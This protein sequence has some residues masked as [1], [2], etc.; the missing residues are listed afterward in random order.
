MVSGLSSTPLGNLLPKSMPQPL[1]DT[2]AGKTTAVI[3]ESP[4]AP[5]PSGTTRYQ[6]T[7]EIAQPIAQT[8]N[9]GTAAVPETV[10]VEQAV[11][12]QASSKDAPLSLQATLNPGTVSAAATPNATPATLPGTTQMSV[13]VPV[14]HAAWEQSMARQVLQAGHNQLQTL[15]IKLNPA[16]L[17]A[18]EVHVKVEAETT[19]IVFSSHHAVVREAVEGAIPRLREMF[20]ASGLNLGNVNVANQGAAEE[21]QG[22]Q[23]SG[24]YGGG[25]TADAVI[26]DQP[27]QPQA[28]AI[29]SHGHNGSEQLLDY[30]I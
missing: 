7:M 29:D 1:R 30:Y 20:G 5:A 14:G 28:T 23:S 15:Q 24:Q 19:S 26:A 17:G 16:H 18:L 6:T 21:Q 13:D 12:L 25:Q 22:R 8:P 4:A 9:A 11:N 10:G 27:E 3:G 2:R